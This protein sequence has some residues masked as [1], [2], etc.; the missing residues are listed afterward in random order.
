[1]KENNQ[2]INISN[3]EEEKITLYNSNNI[4]IINNNMENKPI[5]ILLLL[6][7]ICIKILIYSFK[8]NNHRISSQKGIVKNNTINN[9]NILNRTSNISN[10]INLTNISNISNI[11]NLENITN[12]VYEN[13]ISSSNS[14]IIIDNKNLSDDI[15]FGEISQKESFIKGKKF[16]YD[17]LRGKLMN[18]ITYKSI[19]EPE[20]SIIIPVYNGRKYIKNV[21]RS[22]QNQNFYNMEIILM[23]DFSKDNSLN[24][25][26]EMQKEDKRIKVIM[27]QK[28][29]GIL[30]TRCMGALAAKGKY[31]FTIDM[32]DL[33]FDYDVINTTYHIAEKGNY[34][35][36]AF[37]AVDIKEDKPKIYKITI[38]RF[39]DKN[40]NL[41]IKQPELGVY[42]ISDGEGKYLLNDP[43]IWGKCIKTEIYKKAV[44]DLGEERYSFFN[45]WNE[46]QVILF[47]I[48][49]LSQTY[50]FIRKFGIFHFVHK[51]SSTARHPYKKKRFEEIFLLNI[52][53]EFS[54]GDNKKFAAFK[55][56]QFR[57]WMGKV[58][59]RTYIVKV[60][61]IL[62]KIMKCEEIEKK[63]KEQLIES[64]KGKINLKKYL[65][66]NDTIK[67]SF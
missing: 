17:C 27:N 36:V 31:I 67:K 63:Y 40:N 2:N 21:L 48:C 22:I 33:F 26:K 43:H 5:I 44:N 56:I 18:N 4:K 34:D 19:D 29:M 28:N 41:I 39:H 7:I 47:V 50:I 66:S 15:N 20:V 38:N 1:M 25:I 37:S 3:N 11:F 49:N 52:I 45:C 12:L 6:I 16:L 13:N 60:E 53:F 57:E 64:Y 14:D 9:Y 42:P 10:I 59:R 24:I 32:D 58:L 61:P 62:E 51:A 55:A 35:I 54:R 46:D 65:N 23:D 30:Y 8:Q